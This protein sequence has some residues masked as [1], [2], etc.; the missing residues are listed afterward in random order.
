MQ[1]ITIR[2]PARRGRIEIK[3]A[4]SR[5]SFVFVGG[6]PEELMDAYEQLVGD[7]RAGVAVS[8]DMSNKDYGNGFGSRVSVSLTCNQD[9]QT[10][11]NAIALAGNCARHYLSGQYDEGEKL[12]KERHT[13]QPPGPSPHFG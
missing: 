9:A 3:T 7:G 11:A 10:I 2:L 12:Y 1:E 4:S 5:E 6:P 13:A 8:A